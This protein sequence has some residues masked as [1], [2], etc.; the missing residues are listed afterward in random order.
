MEA[1]G[2]SNYQSIIKDNTASD[3]D[4]EPNISLTQLAITVM[5]PPL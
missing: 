3:E 2:S 1:S 5:I 4:P